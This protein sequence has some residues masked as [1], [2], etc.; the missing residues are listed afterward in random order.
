[1]YSMSITGTIVSNH[2]YT[3]TSA[4]QVRVQHGYLRC[5]TQTIEE[6]RIGAVFLLKV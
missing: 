5:D 1:M 4:V 3:N 2:T 6:N